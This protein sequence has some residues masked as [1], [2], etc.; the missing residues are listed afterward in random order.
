MHNKGGMSFSNNKQLAKRFM[1]LFLKFKH[2][3]KIIICLYLIKVLMN[4]ELKN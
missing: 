1:L 3:M 4:S 2:N